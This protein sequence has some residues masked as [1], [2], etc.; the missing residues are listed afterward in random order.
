MI[1]DETKISMQLLLLPN[2]G[3]NNNN[4]NTVIAIQQEVLSDGSQYY[5]L[6]WEN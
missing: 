1:K 5:A 6:L 2:L 4:N 3:L